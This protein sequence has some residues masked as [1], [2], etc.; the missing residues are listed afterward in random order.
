M[1]SD[2]F[3]PVDISAPP[4]VS[5]G[6]PVHNG[7]A[8]LA[9]AMTSLL[10]Q[11]W[12]DL[13]LIVSDNGSTDGTPQI[14]RLFAARDRRVRVFRSERNLGAAANFNHVVARARGEYFRWAAHDD[15][16]A[17]GYLKACVEV[18][19]RRPDVVLCHTATLRIDEKRANRG[20]YPHDRGG[21]DGDSPA[22]RF[23]ALIN[24]PHFCL[25]IFGLVRRQALLR[26]PL[27]QPHVNSDR[28]LLAEQG[29][30]GRIHVLPQALFYRRDHP[31]TSV[32]R[33]RDDEEGWVSWFDPERAGERVTPTI[34]YIEQLRRSLQRVDL[35]AAERGRC[36][37]VLAAWV[38][39]G[40]DYLGRRVRDRLAEEQRKRD[41]LAPAGS[42][43]VKAS[44]AEDGQR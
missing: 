39:Q 17:P 18:L 1:S 21:F 40:K 41:A 13:E 27:L 2:E 6:L 26:T 24:R 5:I 44:R 38:E 36:E 31:G 15:L 23:E 10:N 34:T 25:A 29:L 7:E 20:V 16:C 42:I 28:N 8:F 33:F 9:E 19:D 12:A 43:T 30:M 35:P 11:S 3:Q 14:C 37:A 32:A 22:A 4:R